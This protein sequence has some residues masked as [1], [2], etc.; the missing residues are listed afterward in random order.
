MDHEA[1]TGLEVRSVAPDTGQSDNDPPSGSVINIK[2]IESQHN[3]GRCKAMLKLK[4]RAVIDDQ[5]A[6]NS[7]K[8]VTE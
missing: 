2:C 6:L 8:N 4:R 7:Q 5:G 1:H 3:M